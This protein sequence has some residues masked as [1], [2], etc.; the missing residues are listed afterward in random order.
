MALARCLEQGCAVH[1]LPQPPF[2]S[3]S[4][5]QLEIALNRA[6]ATNLRQIGITKDNAFFAGWPYWFESRALSIHLGDIAWHETHELRQKEPIPPLVAGQPR[7]Y[8]LN[9]ED[10]QRRRELQQTFPNGE[11]KF[12]QTP[13]PNKSFYLFY[14]PTP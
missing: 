11:L 13:V 4:H 3:A 8:V 7:L 10:K 12:V 5:G 2:L 9:R 6:P 14:I 1:R